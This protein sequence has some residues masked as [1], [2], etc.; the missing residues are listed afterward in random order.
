LAT[1]P[2]GSSPTQKQFRHMLKK[3]YFIL[4]FSLFANNC[5]AQSDATKISCK[6]KIKELFPQTLGESIKTET[7]TIQIAEKNGLI[8]SESVGNILRINFGSSYFTDKSG[9]SQKTQQYNSSDD[10]KWDVMEL[11]TGIKSGDWF[12]QTIQIDR[13][14]GIFNY[15]QLSANR[16]LEA[17]GLC[18]KV[19]TATRKF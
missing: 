15:S 6:A 3:L 13:H 4:F 8:V 12:S 19:N 14:T 18:S 11:R 16:I 1:Q 9:K 2:K 5:W 17:E 10:G 7:F